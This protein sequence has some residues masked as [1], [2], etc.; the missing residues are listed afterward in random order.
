MKSGDSPRVRFPRSL[1]R[2]RGLKAILRDES[3]KTIAWRRSGL[4]QSLESEPHGS[5]RSLVICLPSDYDIVLFYPGSNP[6][7][8]E[9]LS[10]SSNRVAGGTKITHWCQ[11][12]S[13]IHLLN[14]CQSPTV[15]LSRVA[16]VARMGRI[17]QHVLA[18]LTLLCHLAI[19]Y[20]P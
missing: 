14:I 7:A 11:P 1:P 2:R 16:R 6:T 13:C 8:N 9:L 5:V 20:L 4:C 12:I 17:F 15:T 10:P 19:L 18:G 3:E